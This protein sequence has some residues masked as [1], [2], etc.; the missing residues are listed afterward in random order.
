[1]S[2]E[3]ARLAPDKKAN[4]RYYGGRVDPEKLLF[5]PQTLELRPEAK[6]LLAL[7]P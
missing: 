6:K 7:L 1:V 3:G 4:R 2:I 5:G